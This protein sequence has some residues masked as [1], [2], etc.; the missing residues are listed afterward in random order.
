MDARGDEAV[1]EGFAQL[2]AAGREDGAGA[3]VI[4]RYSFDPCFRSRYR[5]TRGWLCYVRPSDFMYLPDFRKPILDAFFLTASV[6]RPSSAA[7]AAVGRLENNLLSCLRSSLVHDP[8]V[9]VLA[10]S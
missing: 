4:V 9:L 1:V 2:T 6:G 7:T 3:E 8:V 5:A 10:I